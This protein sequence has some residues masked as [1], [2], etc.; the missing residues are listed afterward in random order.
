MYGNY[1]STL[2]GEYTTSLRSVLR[3]AQQKQRYSMAF[4]LSDPPSGV[5]SGPARS[6]AGTSSPLSAVVE[7]VEHSCE[8]CHRRILFGGSDGGVWLRRWKRRREL[9]L[10][11]AA[12]KLFLSRLVGQHMFGLGVGVMKYCVI[13]VC[14]DLI[15][16]S[17]DEK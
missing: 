1:F 9:P 12:I 4:L 15:G 16:S 6:L 8:G 13:L 3:S 2:S 17:V 14:F 7:T 10:L 5:R 11:T